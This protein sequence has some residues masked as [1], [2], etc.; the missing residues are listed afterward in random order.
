[1][2]DKYDFVEVELAQRKAALRLRRLRPVTPFSGVEVRAEGRSL[3]NFCSNDYLGLAFHPRVKA[4]AAEYLEAYGAG[5]TASRLIG[6]SHPG[7]ERVEK[8]LA[9][10]KGV[11]K[12][13][14]LNS[15]F[16]AN[17]AL[18]PV[19]ADRH[20]LILADRSNHHSLILGARC[21]RGRV[22]RYRHGDLAHLQR[23][24]ERSHGRSFSRILIVTESVFSMDGD[25]SDV[26]ALVQLATDFQALL[27]VDEAHATGV[28]GPR[29]M[30]L[31]CGK[32][33]DL[34]IGT[35][36]KACGVFGAYVACTERLCEFIVNCCPGFIYSTALPP[37]VL[38]AVDA[39]LEL[40]PEMEE[41]RESLH[42]K[43]GFLR[44]SLRE[45]GWST[46]NSSTQIVPL[47][48]GKER[49]AMELSNWL[50]ENGVLAIAIRPPTVE[51]GKAR[52]RL[53]LSAL[54]TWEHVEYLVDLFRS[55]RERTG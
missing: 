20:S 13:L 55:W 51:P 15:G 9:H 34:V 3:L 54:H 24:L 33:V 49:E 16:Q 12:S 53:A 23:L 50:E 36:G 39:A 26:D 21:S 48:V 28:L 19:L 1:V 30:G 43:A 42:E 18:L 25:R 45:L 52:I 44:R 22:Q 10:L 8:R 11:E 37:A 4:G 47:I 14:V 31:T 35:F 7:F 29:G 17:V 6:G 32:E 38:G 41:E 46:G 2:A 40:V 27:I 5:A